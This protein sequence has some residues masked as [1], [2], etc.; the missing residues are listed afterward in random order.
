MSKNKKPFQWLK[1]LYYSEENRLDEEIERSVNE[2]TQ[3]A[4]HDLHPEWF[5]DKEASLEEYREKL[6]FSKQE[7]YKRMQAWGS[8]K[9]AHWAEILYRFVASLVCV[10]IIS[11]LLQAVLVLPPFGN[12]DNPYNNEVSRRYIEQGLK[13]TGAVNIVAGMILDYRAFDTFGESNVLFAAACSVILILKLNPH[14]K[15][16]ISRAMIEAEYNDRISEPKNDAILQ[17]TARI[18]VPILLLFGF[19]IILNGH[20]SPGGGFSGGAVMGAGLILYLNA[21]GFEKTSR[22][23]TYRTFQLVSLFSLLT[24]CGLK[25]YSFFMGANHYHTGIPLG[26][27]GDILSSGLILPLNI[28]VG[29]VVMCTLYVFYALFRKGGLGK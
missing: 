11:L 24:Y 18:L 1:D 5:A 12:A 3:R 26:N 17:G 25:T 27:P 8:R 23:F 2:P 19:Y 21:F 28:C 14:S 22:F 13:E 7:Q 10:G 16:R 6:R 20:L 9:G 4:L 29:L 15:G